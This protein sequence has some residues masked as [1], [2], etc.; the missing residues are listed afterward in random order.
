MKIT[1][2]R[3]GENRDVY[4]EGSEAVSV[5]DAVERAAWVMGDSSILLNGRA[6][7]GEDLNDGDVLKFRKASDEGGK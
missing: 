7:D 1:V 5:E 4:F 6:Y 3:A 2:Q